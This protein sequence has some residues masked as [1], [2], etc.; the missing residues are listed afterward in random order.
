MSK[1][2]TINPDYTKNHIDETTEYAQTQRHSNLIA[3]CK[4]EHKEFQERNLLKR[5][6]FGTKI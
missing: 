5:E 4:K 2:P 6:K 3:R 1:D